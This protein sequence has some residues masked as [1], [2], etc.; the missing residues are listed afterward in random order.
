[1]ATKFF[2][3]APNIC[4]TS[5]WDFIHVTFIGLRILRRLIDFCKICAPTFLYCVLCITFLIMKDISSSVVFQNDVS[6][7]S[8][9]LWLSLCRLTSTYKK[10]YC[11]F[12]SKF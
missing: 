6:S 11:S 7:A 1:M 9:M 10:K 8:V 5:V 2:T 4:G 3:V 12:N